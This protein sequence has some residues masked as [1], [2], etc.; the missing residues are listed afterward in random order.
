MDKK[1]KD[2]QIHEELDGFDVRINPFG[3]V[4][5]NFDIDKVNEFLNKTTDD[6]KIKSSTP[7]SGDEKKEPE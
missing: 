4:E 7:D 1:E 2:K 5:T 3:Q 6:K